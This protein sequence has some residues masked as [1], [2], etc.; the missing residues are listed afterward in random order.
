MSGSASCSGDFQTTLAADE[1]TISKLLRLHILLQREACFAGSTACID[2]IKESHGYIVEM[3]YDLSTPQPVN[4]L[5]IPSL[6]SAS[7][8]LFPTD[9]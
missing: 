9:G 7:R 2:D 3:K 1:A 4:D 8:I 6:P 5:S